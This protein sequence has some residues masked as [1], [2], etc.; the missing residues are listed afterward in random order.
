MRTNIE[1][2]KGMTY[3]ERLKELQIQY[4]GAYKARKREEAREKAERVNKA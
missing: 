2:L 3:M 4:L 1:V